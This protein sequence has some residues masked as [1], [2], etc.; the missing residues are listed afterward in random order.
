MKSRKS[1]NVRRLGRLSGMGLGLWVGLSI[2]TIARAEPLPEPTVTSESTPKA[3]EVSKP[4]PARYS[5][6]WMM[7]PVSA[8]NVMR[9][10]VALA[11][12]KVTDTQPIL[13]LSS[14]KVRPNLAAIVR[15]GMI[16]ND[17]VKG[18][19]ATAF[20][21]PAIGVLY[22]IPIGPH[23][24]A[25]LIAATT[26]PIGQGG[27]NSSSEARRA[28]N[29]AG[30]FARASMDNALFQINYMTPIV[31][32]GIAYIRDDVTV[33][34][35]AT[36]LELIRVRGEE[37]DKDP[38]RT[39]LVFGLHFGYFL[40]PQLSV[41]GELRYQYWASNGT[42]E[43]KHDASLLDNWTFGFGPRAHFKLSEKMWLR[44]G[45]SLSMN[46]DLPGGFGGTGTEYK[47]V[48]IDVPFF[49]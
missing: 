2:A 23:V 26:I 12:S 47:I 15:F 38:T 49:F 1:G 39:N 37:K 9:A 35:E 45:V 44:P 29:L 32:A 8:A 5:M 31:G 48:Q 16:H 14:Y 22:S 20:V 10:D 30:I 33:Q 27:G 34:A 42:V 46:L 3:P 25:G 13:F 24:K 4:A 18:E 11:F 7:R 6:P 40:I 21:N 19:S 41:G 28:A 17:P 43:K 36:L